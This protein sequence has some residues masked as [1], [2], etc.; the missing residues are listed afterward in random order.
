M[1][2]FLTPDA[3]IVHKCVQCDTEAGSWDG[4]LIRRGGRKRRRHHCGKHTPPRSECEMCGLQQQKVKTKGNNDWFELPD[5]W[6]A[7]P[8][9][10]SRPAHPSGWAESEKANHDRNWPGIANHPEYT[11]AEFKKKEGAPVDR[12][13]VLCG[14]CIV[15]V[16]RA[17]V[18]AF[19]SCAAE[20]SGKN[21]GVIAAKEAA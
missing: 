5:G 12:V 10:Q 14:E 16:K 8:T 17:L 4:E 18:V 11:L 2:R 20:R 9:G 3:P 6:A 1:S 7:W 19:D 15:A 13:M 21:S